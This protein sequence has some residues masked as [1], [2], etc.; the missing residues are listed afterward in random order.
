MYEL[1]RQAGLNGI[2]RCTC[3]RA[4]QVPGPEAKVFGDEQPQAHQSSG[5]FAGQYVS[6]APL[7]ALGIARSGTTLSLRL[8]GFHFELCSIRTKFVE[9]FFGAQILR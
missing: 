9:F 1:E 3:P 6:Y 5:N 4:E 7:D 8:A 2:R